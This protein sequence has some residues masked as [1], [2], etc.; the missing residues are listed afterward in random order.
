MSFIRMKIRYPF[1]NKRSCFVIFDPRME[2]SFIV[3]M[4]YKKGKFCSVK[5]GIWWR[6]RW[7][8]W[9][10]WCSWWRGWRWRWCSWWRRRRWWVFWRWG[11]F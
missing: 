4:I 11:V 10:R 7:W 3:I 5:E 6:W 9:W 8:S 2:K 1:I